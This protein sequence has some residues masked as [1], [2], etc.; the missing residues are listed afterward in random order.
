M[1]GMKKQPTVDWDDPEIFKVVKRFLCVFPSLKSV[2]LR[3]VEDNFAERVFGP[4]ACGHQVNF[5]AKHFAVS[6]AKTQPASAEGTGWKRMG[7]G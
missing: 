2:S 3:F 1:V 5:S 4:Y 7:R 6:K